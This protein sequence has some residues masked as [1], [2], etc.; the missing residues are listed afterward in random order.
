MGTVPN[1]GTVPIFPLA[2]NGERASPE[3]R[4]V[5]HR[6]PLHEFEHVPAGFLNWFIVPSLQRSILEEL[7]TDWGAGVLDQAPVEAYA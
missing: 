1:S 3:D 2:Q 4:P 5:H 6:R 7:M